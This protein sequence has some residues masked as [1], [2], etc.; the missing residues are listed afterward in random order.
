MGRFFKGLIFFISIC[1]I[2]ALLVYG[3]FFWP[4]QESFSMSTAEGRS[5]L[6]DP[7][8]AERA[9]PQAGIEHIDGFD[10]DRS[11]SE[12]LTAA[13]T[14][15][16]VRLAN[17]EKAIIESTALT[18]PDD[19]QTYVMLDLQE[20]RLRALPHAV[21]TG[22]VLIA[23]ISSANGEITAVDVEEERQPPAAF[24]GATKHKWWE[25]EGH[26]KIA[27][28]GDSWFT[29][30][31]QEADWTD[32]L[33]DH[34]QRAHGLTLPHAENM[35]VHNFAV[36]GQSAHYGLVLLGT[37][38]EAEP[39]DHG[40]PSSSLL[41][42]AYDL[43]LIGFNGQ[44][45]TDELEHME[46]MVRTLRQAGTEVV[47]VTTPGGLSNEEGTAAEGTPL[48]QDTLEV[49]GQI[50]DAWGC[51][52]ADA[53]G[54]VAE[55]E[56]QGADVYTETESGIQL[57][58]EGHKAWAEAIRSVLN[59][60]QETP[61]D[62]ALPDEPFVVTRDSDSEGEF[63]TRA[64]VQFEPLE[65]SGTIHGGEVTDELKN[66]AIYYGEKSATDYIITLNEG[67]TAHFSHPQGLAVDFL[68]DLSA[69]FEAEVKI[70]DDDMVID[71][72]S[73][74]E[75]GTHHLGL[76]EGISVE[77]YREFPYLYETGIVV[78]VTSGSMNLV[79]AVY[80]TN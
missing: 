12:G 68:V 62:L 70:A 21:H 52:L 76:V 40:D 56:L 65:H 23:G 43:A 73:G 8:N 13:F 38:A 31:E 14:E 6:N 60:R 19:R 30:D 57:T 45:G 11:Q 10:F 50:A 4:P 39:E 34:E 71:Y 17:G 2:F 75:D 26:V 28:I 51:A 61:V 9:A 77:R 3:K 80:Y 18:V 54:Y 55:A 25:E 59:D 49:M 5:E 24:V 67:E 48:D 15:G 36:P 53:W 22:A 27:L 7:D 16:E 41:A 1:S 78:E 29:E 42:E 44:Q 66:P 63:P 33:F 72:I 46:N 64:E 74:G 47:L 69:A 58:L 37:Q 35:T 79:G 20:M 32:L